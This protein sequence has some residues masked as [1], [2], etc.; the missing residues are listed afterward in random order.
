M[1]LSEVYQIRQQIKEFI[2]TAKESKAI[3]GEFPLMPKISLD[4]GIM[5]KAKNVYVIPGD[6]GWDDVGEKIY[7]ISLKQSLKFE[8]VNYFVYYY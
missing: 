1:Y 3:A 6:F 4:Y 7:V 8:N 5:E 2:G